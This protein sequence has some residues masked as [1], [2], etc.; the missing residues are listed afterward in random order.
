MKY[1]RIVIGC[2][3]N[4]NLELYY[5]AEVANIMIITSYQEIFFNQELI[6]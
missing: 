5:F 4:L 3:L 1:R 6:F 2:I